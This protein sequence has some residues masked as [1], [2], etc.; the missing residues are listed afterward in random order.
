MVDIDPDSWNMSYPAETEVQLTATS[1]D[2]WDFVRWEGDVADP[3]NNVTTVLM[4]QD[5]TV[6]AVFS[7]KQ[8]VKPEQPTDDGGGKKGLCF[9]NTAKT[10]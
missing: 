8:I 6:K 1:G 9:I 7:E 4:D 5:Q 10:P 2:D 3:N